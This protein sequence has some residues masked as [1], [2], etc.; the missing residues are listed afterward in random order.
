MRTH[1]DGTAKRASGPLSPTQPEQQKSGLLC[2]LSASEGERER[3]SWRVAEAIRFSSGVIFGDHVWHF[4]VRQFSLG[5]ITQEFLGDLRKM[6]LMA[7]TVN[8]RHH[9]FPH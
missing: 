9:K 7:N 1:F 5:Q 3:K 6:P 4:P 2:G 8:W